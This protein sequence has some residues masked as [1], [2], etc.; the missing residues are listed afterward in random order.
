MDDETMPPL[1]PVDPVPEPRFLVIVIFKDG[2]QISYHE[3]SPAETLYFLR[4]DNLSL[5]LVSRPASFIRIHRAE[6]GEL[7]ENYDLNPMTTRLQKKSSP[8][9]KQPDHADFC[10]H[11]KFVRQIQEFFRKNLDPDHFASV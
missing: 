10:H 7:Y 3:T 5:L 1:E 9:K 2:L 8:K 11:V 4:S 6:S